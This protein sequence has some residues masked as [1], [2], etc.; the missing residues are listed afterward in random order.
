MLYRP[1]LLPEA[2]TQQLHRLRTATVALG[3]FLRLLEF[4]YMSLY[5]FGEDMQRH[6]DG[7]QRHADGLERHVTSSEKT[8]NALLEHSKALESAYADLSTHSNS[9]QDEYSRLL[10]SYRSLRM[11]R[12]TI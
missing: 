4:N 2:C 12:S 10:D 6:A 7:L 9:L 5:L 1:E 3:D 11:S 8:Y